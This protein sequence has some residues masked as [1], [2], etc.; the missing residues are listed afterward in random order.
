MAF[1]AKRF[2]F[3]NVPSE[4]YSLMI[5]S[6]ESGENT[7]NMPGDIKLYSEKLFRRTDE[8]LFG[9]SV[10]PMLEFPVSFTTDN[11]E[12]TAKDLQL[13]GKWLFGRKNYA[14]LRIIQEDME[15]VYYDC[16]LLQPKIYRAGNIIRGV[17]ATVHC[18]NAWGISKEKNYI[19]GVGSFFH[20]N[21]SDNN[22]YTYPKTTITT[23]VF[24]GTITWINVSDNNR[25][26]SI[27]GLLANE[28]VTI[29]NDLQIITS[30][31]GLRRLSNFN[32]NFFRLKSGANNI[33]ITGAC[34][35]FVINYGMAKKVGG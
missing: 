30:D 23:D 17:S 35:S 7:T 34:S 9:V 33:I 3:D 5:S 27:T 22:D 14:E 25:V 31:T 26:S 4:I 18:R 21:L 10:E 20:N 11:D 15:D 24:G 32:K 29:D 2:V 13:I 12:L 8:Y 28:V 6:F 16:F 19:Y 1:Y